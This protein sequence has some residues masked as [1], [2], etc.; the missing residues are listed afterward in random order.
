MPNA[1]EMVMGSKG[2]LPNLGVADTGREG[3]G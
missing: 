3:F 2:P 1:E